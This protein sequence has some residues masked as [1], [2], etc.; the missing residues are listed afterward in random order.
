M[1]EGYSGPT[2]FEPQAA[3][4]LFAQLLGDNL[5]MPRKPL[6]DPGRNVNFNPGEFD[7]KIGSR[8]LPDWMD[9]T[10][11]PPEPLEWKAAGRLLSVRSGRRLRKPFP[12]SRRAIL[13]SFLTT[14]QPIKGSSTFERT[15]APGRQL[16]REQRSHRQ[17]FREGQ[18]KPSSCGLEEKADR[19]VQ[20]ARQTLRHAGAQIWIIRSRPARSELQALGAGQRQ[21]GGSVR[22]VSPP[23]LVYRVYPDGREELVRGLRFR[24]VSTRS[25]RDVLAASQRNHFVR[26][27]QQRRAARVHGRRRICSRRRRS[28]RP[29]FCSKKSNSSCRRISCPIAR[30]ACA[31]QAS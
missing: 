2:L 12:W 9:V 1:G 25:L 5:R 18:P 26:F 28:S 17:S 31:Q 29:A 24:G 3:A 6:A 4:Q 8:I 7:T 30:C 15:R 16:R 20:A 10:D 23:L 21:S 11:N 27:C 19:H 22:P 14:R 13:K